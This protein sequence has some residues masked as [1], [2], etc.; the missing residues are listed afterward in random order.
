MKDHLLTDLRTYL[1]NTLIIE[2]AQSLSQV[3]D[4]RIPDARFFRREF[5]V[6][7]LDRDGRTIPRQDRVSCKMRKDGHLMRRSVRFEGAEGK[8]KHV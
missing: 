5:I 4:P 7:Y 1:L 6:R 3:R 2:T 8:P